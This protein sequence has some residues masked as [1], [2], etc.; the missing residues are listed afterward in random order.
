ATFYFRLSEVE[1]N[2]SIEPFLAPT[3][4]PE[5][6]HTGKRQHFCKDPAQN[7]KRKENRFPLRCLIK[8]F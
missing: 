8:T 7:K 6:V 3:K 5:T 2:F 1:L 4:P